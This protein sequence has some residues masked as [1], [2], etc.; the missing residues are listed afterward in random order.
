[1]KPAVKEGGEMRGL[2]SLFCLLLFPA[3][4]LAADPAEKYPFRPV[5][6]ITGS[7]GSTSDLAARFIAQKFTERWGQ[8]VVVDNRPGAGGVI[9]TEIA[10]RSAPDGNTLVIGHVGTHAS[11]PALHKN[12][13]YDPIRDFE[14]ISNLVNV[15][16]VLVVHPSVPAKGLKEFIAYSRGKPGVVNHGSPGLGTSGHLT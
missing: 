9:G 12:L 1:M 10:A 11:A 7:A 6:I 14:P 3:G 8:Q 13:P 16:I 15:A 2:W 5:R 4:A